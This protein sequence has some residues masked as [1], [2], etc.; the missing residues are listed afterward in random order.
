[1][2]NLG[3]VKTFDRLGQSIVVAVADA[4]YRR[5]DTGFGQALGVF[6]RDVLG[7]SI[8]VMHVPTA[9]ARPPV[10]KRLFQRIEYE[11]RVRRS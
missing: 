5:L 3:F 11:A 1:M 6:D 7:A 4:A 8:A 9:M 2:D 10:M